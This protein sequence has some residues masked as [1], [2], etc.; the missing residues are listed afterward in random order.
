M[1]SLTADF[2]QEAHSLN[3]DFSTRD[4][5]NILRFAIKRMAQDPEHPL[6]RDTAWR[7]A[8]ERCLGEDAMD[9]RSLAD[10]RS[11]TLGGNIVPMGL[12]D[13]FFS[14]DDPLHPDADGDDDFDD[15]DFD[16]DDD[17]N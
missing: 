12:G 5:I 9:L 2:L 3:L 8:L 11:S 7:E 15:D 1:L 13:F 17:D 14:P 6:A 16:D 10:K 4:G